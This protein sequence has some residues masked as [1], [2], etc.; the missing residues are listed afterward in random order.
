M[1]RGLIG[2]PGHVVSSTPSFRRMVAALIALAVG[3]VALLIAGALWEAQSRLEKAYEVAQEMVQREANQLALNMESA[4]HG[5]EIILADY[6]AERHEGGG[7]QAG[8]AEHLLR[9]QTSL[10]PGLRGMLEFDLSG[11][12][13]VGSFHQTTQAPFALPERVLEGHRDARQAEMIWMPP[14]GEHGTIAISR[15]VDSPDGLFAGV[16]V[17]L[18][19]VRP[20]FERAWSNTRPPLARAVIDETGVLFGGLSDDLILGFD[21]TGHVLEEI[22]WFQGLEKDLLSRGGHFSLRQSG[23]IA[24]IAEGGGMPL[25]AIVALRQSEIRALWRNDVWKPRLLAVGWFGLLAFA[26]I[27]TAALFARRWITSLETLARSERQFNAVFSQTIHVAALLTPDGRILLANHAALDLLPDPGLDLEGVPFWDACWWR[28]EDFAALRAAVRAVTPQCPAR[29]E[30]VVPVWR[31]GGERVF[32]LSIAAIVTEGDTIDY[33]LAEGRDITDSK[34]QQEVI[35]DNERR[36]RDFY[37]AASDWFW[38]MDED[39]RYTALSPNF[40]RVMHLPAQWKMGKRRWE[41]SDDALAPDQAKKWQAHRECLLR[42]ESFRDFEYSVLC[43][44]GRRRWVRISGRPVFD[45]HGLFVGYRGTGSEITAQREAEVARRSSEARFELAVDATLNGLWDWDLRTDLVWFSPRWRAQMGYDEAEQAD[46]MGLRLGL[47][48]ESDQAAAV[49]TMEDFR[50]GRVERLD[51]VQ[52]FRRTDGTLLFIHSRAVAQRNAEGLVIRVVGADADIT[53]RLLAEQTLRD[54]EERFRDLANTVP[55]MLYQWAEGPEGPRYTYVSP[56]SKPMFGLMPEELLAD[57]RR[58]AIH[59]DDMPRWQES[60]ERATARGADWEFEGRFILP[61]GDIRWWRGLAR[62]MRRD[63]ETIYNGIVLDITDAKK[64]EEERARQSLLLQ[65]INRTQTDFIR[66]VG[67][68]KPFANLLARIIEVMACRFG[69]VA[70]V[71]SGVSGDDHRGLGAEISEAGEAPRLQTVAV[72]YGPLGSSWPLEGA[73]SLAINGTALAEPAL[74]GLPLNLA[75]GP[76][77]QSFLPKGAPPLDNFLGLPLRMGDRVMGVLGLGNRDG[78]FDADL[79]AFLGPVLRSGAALIIAHRQELQRRTMET[80]LAQTKERLEQ[81]AA[82]LV[83]SN[84]ELEAFAYVTSHDLRQPVRMIKS[85]VQL[86][87]EELDG[88]LSEASK[89]YLFFTRDGAE[90]M[91]RLIVDLL[92][93][94]RIGRRVRPFE[95]IDFNLVCETALAPLRLAI[96]EAKAV[97]SVPSEA[98]DGYSPTICGDEME[99]S[100]VVQNLVGNALKY[101]SPDHPPVIDISAREEGDEWLFCVADNGIGIEAQYYDR[102][103]QIFQRLHSRDEYEGTGIGLAICKK[104]I[105]RHKGRIWVDSEPGRGSRFYFTLPKCRDFSIC[106]GAANFGAPSQKG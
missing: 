58:L 84:A 103:F 5:A 89:E 91:D 29:M 53:Q 69:F 28:L 76:Q 48:D 44:D 100:R 36:F 51:L 106:K 64:I 54:S 87:E 1:T 62:P 22:P 17:A 55:G 105:E 18:L 77:D 93:Y 73:D 40:E 70:E 72:S 61:T 37:E 11:K 102:I 85:Y 65:L 13:R 6:A 98:E 79:E 92:E 80:D 7:A 97:V 94:S 3:A 14:R 27:A 30:I 10:V 88:S 71:I 101:R 32:D 4:L 56:R 83:R 49:Q 24:A 63:G 26:L 78:G 23:R 42:R 47:V 21:D 104:I 25:R 74:S 8:E 86:L 19:D 46:S 81:Q 50:A 60:L 95:S 2:G 12:F 20:I 15:R 41:I 90:R 16:A 39:L 33:L 96:E 43:S 99:L 75:H 57:W 35:A 52:R 34:R 31:E 68:T 45:D 66:D 67:G 82:E 38:E 9:R 59:P